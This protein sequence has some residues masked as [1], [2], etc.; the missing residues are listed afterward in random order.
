MP[1]PARKSNQTKDSCDASNTEISNNELAKLI[2]VRIDELEESLNKKVLSNQ[3]DIATNS[4]NITANSSRIDKL[5]SVIAE[6]ADKISELNTDLD[7]VQNRA[8][9]KTLIFKN[10]PKKREEVTWADTKNVLTNYISKLFDTEITPREKIYKQIERAHRGKSSSEYDGPPFIF[11]QFSNWSFS[12]KVKELFL[13]DSINNNSKIYV[14]QMF[15]KSVTARRVQAFD[16]RK[17][18]KQK[19]PTMK[20]H[21]RY[22]ATLMIKYEGEDVYKKNKVF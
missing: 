7:D 20:C 14:S 1:G 8:L 21:I 15:S 5:E 17:E 9:R 3:K 19:S 13:N 18:L 16:Y 4:D 6:Q 12:E 2:T 10:I 11:V 22:P